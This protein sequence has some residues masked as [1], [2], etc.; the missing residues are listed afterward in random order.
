MVYF[1]LCK[2]TPIAGVWIEICRVQCYVTYVKVTP[3]AGVWIEIGLWLVHYHLFWSL[4]LRECGLKSRV[5]FLGL[6]F[7]SHSHCGSVD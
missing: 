6:L 1:L 2:V 3:I 5:R 7:T 4:P